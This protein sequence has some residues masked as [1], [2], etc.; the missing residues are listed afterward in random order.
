MA[1]LIIPFLM[2]SPVLTVVPVVQAQVVY[3]SAALV[4]NGDVGGKVV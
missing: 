4:Q 3:D 2:V 1:E